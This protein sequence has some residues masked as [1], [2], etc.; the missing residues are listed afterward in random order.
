MLNVPSGIFNP[1]SSRATS[2][3]GTEFTGGPL[4]LFVMLSNAKHL[5]RDESQILRLRLRMTITGMTL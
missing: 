2:R 1:K 3:R 4:S 5:A